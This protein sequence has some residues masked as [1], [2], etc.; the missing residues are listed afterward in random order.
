[1]LHPVHLCSFRIMRACAWAAVCFFMTCF[2]ITHPAAALNCSFQE[3]NGVV[4]CKLGYRGGGGTKLA[5]V[6]S[7]D[8]DHSKEALHFINSWLRFPPCSTTPLSPNFTGEMHPDRDL[9]PALVLRLSCDWGFKKC[10]AVAQA[11]V[12]AAAPHMHCFSDLIL[13]M[14]IVMFRNT[15]LGS[16][17]ADCFEC[18]CSCSVHAFCNVCPRF[19]EDVFNYAF[20]DVYPCF[21]DTLAA[22]H[23]A[24]NP[25]ALFCPRS[26]QNAVRH[27]LGADCSFLPLPNALASSGFAAMMYIGEL[28]FGAVHSVAM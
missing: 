15:A 1:M 9:L 11:L 23:R 7:S 24:S 22:A 10:E 19:G 12:G 2:S 4:R 18:V 14:N 28:R 27:L 21:N 25:H 13:K 8:V 17:V 3:I 26:E 6:V 5:V 20:D 16:T